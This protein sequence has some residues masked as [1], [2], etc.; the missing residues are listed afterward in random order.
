MTS[1]NAISIA[2]AFAAVLGFHQRIIIHEQPSMAITALKKFQ[3]LEAA[4]VWRA[5]ADAQR[6]DVI[7]S[8]GEATLTITDLQDRPLAHWSLAAVVRQNPG[9][10][11]ALF[12]PAGDADETLEIGADET[13]MLEAIDKVH[14]A[15]ER[16]RPRPGRLR[17]FG[18]L[19][20]IAVLGTLAVT[21][22][23][24]ALQRHALSV[25]S[26]INRKAIG[27]ALLGRIER[28]S[29]QA[30]ISPETLPLLDRLATRTDVR[31]IVV[32]RQGVATSLALPGGIYLLNSSYFEDYEDPAIVAGAILVERGRAKAE[33]P[34]LSLL[35][36]GG[37]PAA[38]HLL[39]TGELRRETLD[40]YAEYALTEPR[41]TLNETAILAEFSQSSLPSSPYAY[42]LDITGETT[43]G[44][45]EA[46]P[47]ANQD[48]VPL[49]NDQQWVQLQN[50][51]S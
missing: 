50:I 43:L 37:L 30:C 40:A 21:W 24:N 35:S 46:D 44:L 27:Q 13:T 42:A 1:S 10:L 29:G 34:L 19:G 16:A 6:R 49:L 48:V 39:T 8:I 28:L 3:R 36:V 17:L 41:P 18:G 23:P 7:A 15:I 45:I 51:C 14:A 47:L 31:K 20:V 25:V 33:D 22:L 32:L 26:D 11:P 2:A 38:F 12:S 5:T 4:G 9:Q